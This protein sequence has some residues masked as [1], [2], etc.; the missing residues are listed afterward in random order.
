MPLVGSREGECSAIATGSA[1]PG[2]VGLGGWGAG[3]AALESS[4]RE[5][6]VVKVPLQHFC[7]RNAFFWCECLLTRM[8]KLNGAVKL[9]GEGVSM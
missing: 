4:L 7:G 2:I 1:L 9:V 6:Q 3:A 8:V 5:L